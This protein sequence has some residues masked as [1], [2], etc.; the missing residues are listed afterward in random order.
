MTPE[1]AREY[2]ITTRL[3]LIEDNAPLAEATAKFLRHADLEVRVA[4]SGEE[5][6][7]TALTFLPEIVLCDIRLPD[8]S[9]LNVLHALRSHPDTK[10]AML[11]IYSAMS[12]VDLRALQLKTPSDVV[13]LFLPKPLSMEKIDR[14]LA[15]HAAMRQGTSS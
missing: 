14:L 7:R 8:M 11:A 4:E 13:D 2:T 1:P 3:L 6:L 15:A 9:G 5:A 10:N 12:D